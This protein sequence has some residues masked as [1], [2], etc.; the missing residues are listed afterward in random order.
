MST[1]LLALQQQALLDALFAWPRNSATN[2]LAKYIDST[3]ARGLLSYQT[4]GHELAQRALAAAYPVLVQLLGDD[5]FAALARAFWHAEPPQR[6]DLAQWGADLP[7]FVRGSEQL[8]N[9]PY[10]GDVA[11][12]EWA[13]HCTAGSADRVAEPT[14]FAL[15]MANDPADLQ[16]VLAPG[17]VAL[18]SPW[19]AASI[20]TAHLLADSSALATAGQKLNEGVAEDAV[21]WREHL[22]PRLR[23]ALPG[24]ADFVSA[25]Q[26]DAGLAGNLGGA[27]DAAPALDF[28]VWLP[29]AV[30]S[31]LLLGVKIASEAPSP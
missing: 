8:S 4:N 17:C 12:I 14:T 21:V 25:L 9:E 11:R 3:G 27:V 23:E 10:L 13:L 5:S 24:E 22:R 20:V 7:D 1:S 31:G 15:L 18:R 29:L 16:L 6:G 30:Q 2:N 28:A 26:N 19:P